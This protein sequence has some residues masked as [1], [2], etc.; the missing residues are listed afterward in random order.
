MAHTIKA[1]CA[2]WEVNGIFYFEQ[3][4]RAVVCGRWTKVRMRPIGY[5]NRQAS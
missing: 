5:P 4:R 1:D 3:A 2:A